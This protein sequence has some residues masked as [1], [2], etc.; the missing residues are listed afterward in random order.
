MRV[1][2]VELHGR[3]AIMLRIRNMPRC[4]SDFEPA[5]ESE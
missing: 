4:I 2:R 3:F 1:S 5:H